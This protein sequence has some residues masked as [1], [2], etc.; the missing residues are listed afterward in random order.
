ME[1]TID[2]V[3]RSRKFPPEEGKLLDSAPVDPLP[4]VLVAEPDA[5][6]DAEPVAEPDAEPEPPVMPLVREVGLVVAV[7][8][9]L[10]VVLAGTEV[11]VSMLSMTD[12]SSRHVA[13]LS[14]ILFFL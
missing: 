2:V 10:L 7:G 9:V 13:M 8:L 6:P 3:K 4:P 11:T 1:K 5:E 14:P 12:K